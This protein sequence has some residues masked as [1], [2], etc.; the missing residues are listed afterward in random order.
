MVKQLKNCEI[1]NS[2]KWKEIY[3]GKI[4]D[5][6]FVSFKNGFIVTWCKTCNVDRLDKKFCLSNIDDK[7]LTYR[8]KLETGVNVNSYFEENNKNY[9]LYFILSKSKSKTELT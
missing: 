8:M 6:K 9:C 7:N 5:G 2:K 1:C 3:S 4:K